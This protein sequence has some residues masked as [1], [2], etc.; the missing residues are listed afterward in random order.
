MQVHGAEHRWMFC[1]A[2]RLPQNLFK[3]RWIFPEWQREKRC[4]TVALPS[5]RPLAFDPSSAF[6]EDFFFLQTK[7][8]EDRCVLPHFFPLPLYFSLSSLPEF[9]QSTLRVADCLSRLARCWAAVRPGGK[10]GN[11]GCRKMAQM[12]LREPWKCVKHTHTHTL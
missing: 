5:P 8:A 3:K 12:V 1:L 9:C 7:E 11:F 2:V 6:Q 4:P 10:L